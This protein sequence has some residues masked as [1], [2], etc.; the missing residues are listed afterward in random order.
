MGRS[1]LEWLCFFIA[2][3]RR[4]FRPLIDHLCCKLSSDAKAAAFNKQSI[5][6]TST[7]NGQATWL[8]LY[9]TEMDQGAVAG[10]S[11]ETPDVATRRL[12][13]M[14]RKRHTIAAEFAH[15]MNACPQSVF[16][17][18]NSAHLDRARLKNQ[19]R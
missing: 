7:S 5:E 13:R 11:E 4:A 16:R 19:M 9:W 8:R 12:S 18:R 10:P 15:D 17:S 6:H 2:V 3:V 1:S 14:M